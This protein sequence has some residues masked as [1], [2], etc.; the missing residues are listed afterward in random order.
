MVFS[1]LSIQIGVL[2][3]GGI[4]DELNIDQKNHSEYTV[5]RPVLMLSLMPTYDQVVQSSKI[6]IT[7]VDG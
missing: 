6:P 5:N 1:R 4:N 7:G 3:L 2:V